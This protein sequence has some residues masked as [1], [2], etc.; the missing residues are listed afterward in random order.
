MS[1]DEA[2]SDMLRA[3]DL[4]PP[5]DWPADAS[6]VLLETLQDSDAPVEERLLAA[7]LAGQIVAINDDL[8]HALLSIIR[9]PN[10]PD[11][12]RGKAA[13]ALGPVLELAS[14]DGFDD[15]EDVPITA[16]TFQ[17]IEDSLRSLYR[18]SDIPG[19]VRRRI[20]EASVRSPQD[21]H[22]DAV[23]AA[24]YSGDKLWQ[25]TAVF[26]MRYV[27]SFEE[28]ILEALGNPDQRIQAEAV[29]AAG[30]WEL[31]AAWPHIRPL[32]LGPAAKPLVLVAIEAAAQINHEEAQD[33][34]LDLVR[35]RDEEIA[36]AAEEALMMAD[37]L[38]D[39]DD[40]Y[41]E[42]EDERSW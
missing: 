12:L 9:T 21:W 17:H 26:A 18:D 20:L 19:E 25:L 27:N 30:E 23:R 4:I 33:L 13:I 40:E 22:K 34:L 41:L 32:L 39:W 28:Q 42:D 6:D 3:L 36:D 7:Q 38:R 37:A 1:N 10:L 11:K 29:Q 8:A 15:P 5:W 14:T 35:S 24:Y 16:A 31:A 2:R